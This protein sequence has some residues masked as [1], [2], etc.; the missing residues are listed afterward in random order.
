MHN[1]SVVACLRHPVLAFGLICISIAATAQRANAPTT[2]PANRPDTA[3]SLDQCIAYAL[4]NQPTV[5]QAQISVAIAHANNKI[6]TA[7]WLPRQ[8]SRAT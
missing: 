4:K 2:Q 6:N 8:A 1:I 5:N 3:L 7:G